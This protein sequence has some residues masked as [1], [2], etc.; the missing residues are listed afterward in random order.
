MTETR[1]QRRIRKVNSGRALA[2]ACVSVVGLVFGTGTAA[3]GVDNA[4]SLVD[5]SGDRIEV[6]QGDTQ[7][8]AVPPLDS[9]PLSREFFH[10][11][12]AE[13]QIT[14]PHAADAKA[15]KLTFGYQLGYP[16]A[17]TGATIQLNTPSLGFELETTNAL[18]LGLQQGTNPDLGLALGGRAELLGDIIPQQNFTLDLQP[19]GITD[20]PLVKDKAFDGPGTRIRLAGVHGS[21]SGAIGPV[22]IRPYAR[23]ETAAGDI[24]MTYGAP[25]PL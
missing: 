4:N 9:S 21:V 11:G 13:V 14:G 18:T 23:A 25:V 8:N 19:G 2:V 17:L 5:F 6:S 24:V 7:I 15:T 10:N 1:N 22:T 3:A 12:Y 16:I 20:V